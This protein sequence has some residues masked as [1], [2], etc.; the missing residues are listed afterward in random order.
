MKDEDFQK[1]ENLYKEAGPSVVPAHSFENHVLGVYENAKDLLDGEN[2]DEEV[3]EYATLLHDVGRKI[4][5]DGSHAER[6]ATKAEEFLT[7]EL[8][9]T[10][11]LLKRFRTV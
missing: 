9:K 8:K 2:V 11:N 5:G 4:Q 10:R 3:V 1:I 7:E 6:G